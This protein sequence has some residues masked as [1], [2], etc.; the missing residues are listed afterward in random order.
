MGMS[1]YEIDQRIENCFDPDTGEIK[2]DLDALEI[3]R[4]EKIDNIACFIKSL[5]AEA[6]AVKAEKANLYARQKALENKAERLQEYL[7]QS[8]QGEKFKSSRISIS[9]R[10]SQSVKAD[11]SL[12]PEKY[13]RTYVEADKTAIKEELKQGKEVKGA[14]LVTNVSMIIK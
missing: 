5:K 1:L 3:E 12:L 2:E 8:L 11:T 9:Y 4:A 6:E 7:Q 14:E 13:T 10:K